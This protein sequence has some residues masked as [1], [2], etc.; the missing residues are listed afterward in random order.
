MAHYKGNRLLL[1]PATFIRTILS[2][3][4]VKAT[5]LKTIVSNC[6]VITGRFINTILADTKVVKRSTQTILADTKVR[7][8]ALHSIVSDAK[9][10]IPM[11]YAT[12]IRYHANKLFISCDV[13]PA[14]FCVVDITDDNVFPDGFI[15][16][17]I[18]ED[19][20]YAKVVGINTTFDKFYLGCTNGKIAKID[21]TNPLLREELDV[22]DS[23]TIISLTSFDAPDKLFA[24]TDSA[25]FE[26]YILDNALVK[27]IQADLRFL[28]QTVKTIKTTLSYVFKTIAQADLRF[29]LR[30]TKT[31]ATDL[32][33]N[34]VPYTAIQGIT[35][36]D[37]EL[38]INGGL[39]TDVI[40][41]SIRV[42]LNV[43]EDAQVQFTLSRKHD[44]IDYTLDGV[45]NQ[46]SN[47]N[48]VDVYIKGKHIFAGKV[49][50][51]EGSSSDEQVTVTALGEEY[52]HN[53][54]LITL[55]IPSINEQ[56]HL[57]HVLVDDVSIKNPDIAPD[58]ENPPYYKGIKI[59][60]GIWEIESQYRRD[61]HTP[62]YDLE[63]IIPD[64]NYTYFWNVSGMNFITGESFQG[65]IGKYIGTSL[66]PVSS[67][68]FLIDGVG[69]WQQRIFPNIKRTLGDYLLGEPPYKE[70][71]VKNG[72]Y[73]S[74]ERWEDRQDG[75]YAVLNP[76]YDY[77]AW[78]KAVADVE[79]RK[80]QT[81]N[82]TILP[83]T[84]ATLTV[85]IDAFL[86]YNLQLLQRINIGNTT[87]AGIYQNAN[88]FPLSIKNITIDC[89]SMKVDI[90][91]DNELAQSELDAID[92]TLPTEPHEKPGY[93]IL[94]KQKY[95]LSAQ[96]YID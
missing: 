22:L 25:T 76:N 65:L 80:L 29:L 47:K 89:S 45:Y 39:S 94:I 15:L 85:T 50:N 4:T 16:D 95:D 56:L 14:K 26:Y 1:D 37:I 48:A 78:A 30:M 17:G 28:K 58:E 19:Y 61:A 93:A 9:I 2:D 81:I 88:G 49:S 12:E 44:R 5:A 83:R 27:S 54:N 70:I 21:M 91:V 73:T 6:K 18:G 11:E 71:S 79:Y 92:D 33:Y 69:F 59:D 10:L 23:D 38:H 62:W 63:E 75:L 84:S 43:D 3:A 41:A 8:T 72:A 32:R 82:G 55:N 67:D 46:I 86:Y 66:S 57:Y 20:H 68:T 96:D 7:G 52:S 36:N 74:W 53:T 51:I 13:T 42:M 77:V 35:A 24:A 60:K 40:Q 34:V 90:N 64:Q 31:V 87:Q